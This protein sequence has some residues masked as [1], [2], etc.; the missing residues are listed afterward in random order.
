MRVV[1]VILTF[2]ELLHAVISY[3]HLFPFYQNNGTFSMEKVMLNIELIFSKFLRT[4]FIGNILLVYEIVQHRSVSNINLIRIYTF[5]DSLGWEVFKNAKL[6]NYEVSKHVKKK[7]LHVTQVISLKTYF[8]KKCPHVL[9]EKMFTYVGIRT[10]YF[11]MLRK[12]CISTSMEEVIFDLPSRTCFTNETIL[13]H[14]SE[15]TLFLKCVLC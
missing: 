1:F 2:P 8:L 14:L 6:I 11:S 7:F 12:K 15:K 13:Q 10:H 4:S 9:T 5:H 3:V